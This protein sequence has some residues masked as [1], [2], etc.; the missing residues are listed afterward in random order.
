MSTTTTPTWQPHPDGGE[1]LTVTGTPGVHLG[2]WVNPTHGPTWSA[3]FDKQGSFPQHADTLDEAKADAIAHAERR[4]GA[5][6]AA[7]EEA[8]RVLAVL[9]GAAERKPVAGWEIGHVPGYSAR[10]AAPILRR[11]PI[12]VRA[13]EA[14][15][16]MIAESDEDDVES[17]QITRWPAANT[18]AAQLAAED[19][20]FAIADAINALRGR[21]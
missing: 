11:G 18:I 8:A 9:R 21:K 16:E 14:S 3:A 1:C 17:I 19:A 7:G 6:V 2:A 20:L 13:G 4:L 15:W 12:C 5:I 10:R